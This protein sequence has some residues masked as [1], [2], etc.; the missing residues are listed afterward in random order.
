MLIMP[1]RRVCVARV[2]PFAENG[3]NIEEPDV[4]ESFL[5]NMPWVGRRSIL[6]GWLRHQTRL[7]GKLSLLRQFDRHDRA[8]DP[9]FKNGMDGL[10]G[11]YEQWKR[12][13]KSKTFHSPSISE[14][15]PHHHCVIGRLT[16]NNLM[17]TAGPQ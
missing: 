3:I 8:K 16:H 12:D 13:P 11:S 1:S 6:T 9:V 4:E 2:V 5:G 10:H 17:S 14:G 15:L 7:K